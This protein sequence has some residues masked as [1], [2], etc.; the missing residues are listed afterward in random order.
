MGMEVSTTGFQAVRVVDLS[1]LRVADFAPWVGSKF[2]VATEP[3]I[4]M[5]IELVEASAL[6]ARSNLPRAEPFSLIFGGAS[7][8]PLDQRIHILEHD[9]LGRLELFLVPIGP[10]ADGNGPRY[11]SIFN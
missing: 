2:R 6:S 9:G 7:G 4:A 1:A 10:G 3:G 5:S 8:H 11:Q